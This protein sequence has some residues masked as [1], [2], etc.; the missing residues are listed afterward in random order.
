M[1]SNKILDPACG[2][3]MMWFNRNHPNVIYG[4]VRNEK[5]IL[6]DGRSLQIDPDFP[7]DF[8]A[9]PF[10]DGSFKLVV[11]DPPH[12]VRCGEKSW[13]LKKYGRLGKF[14]RE[15][16]AAGFSECF[17]VLEYEGILIFKWSET[18]IKTSEVLALTDRQPLFGHP[19]GK[20]ANTHWICFMNV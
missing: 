3:K 16:L 20:R 19:S 4:D 12:L 11:F 15:D 6:C 17:R 1:P 7:M 14:W 10:A 9:L 18:Q 8:T 5:H 2:S 13:L